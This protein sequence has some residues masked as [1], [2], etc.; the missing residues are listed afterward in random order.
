GD[1][2]DV[3]HLARLEH[4]ADADLGTDRGRLF[5]REPELA[6]HGEGAGTRLLELALH[7]LRQPPRLGSAEAEL[8]GCVAVALG[9]AGG[10]HRTRARLEDGDRPEDALGRIHLRHAELPSQRPWERYRYRTL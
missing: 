9:L 1:A 4:V 5:A 10:D 8:R 2:G 3:H 6:Q 7:G